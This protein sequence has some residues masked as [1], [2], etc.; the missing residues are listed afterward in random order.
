MS[1]YEHSEAIKYH[2][3][4]Q[5]EAYALKNGIDFPKGSLSKHITFDREDIELIVNQVIKI[6]KNPKKVKFNIKTNRKFNIKPKN[7]SD[8]DL[9]VSIC[10]THGLEYFEFYD[11]NNWCG[12]ALKVDEAE[13][14]IVVGY[15]NS[16]EVH[17]VSGTD[18]Y[19][20]H[21]KN[22]C[23]NNFSQF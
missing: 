12:P 17:S 6:K 13:Y 22:K 10:V 20:I 3:L 16:I 18:F 1:I 11:E 8:Y 19:I 7:D 5:V 4:N 14:D 21:P 9:F 15:F 2:I 23:E